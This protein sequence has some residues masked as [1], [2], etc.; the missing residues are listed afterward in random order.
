M[1]QISGVLIDWGDGPKIS[2]ELIIKI[3]SFIGNENEGEGPCWM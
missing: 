3:S 1:W 2:V